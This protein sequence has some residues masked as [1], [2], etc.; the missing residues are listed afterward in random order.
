MSKLRKAAQGQ[1]CMVRLPDCDGGGDTTVL[2]HYRMAGYCGVGLKPDDE[3]AAW[4]C[5]PCHAAIDGRRKLDGWTREEIRLAHAEGVM[6]T[7]VERKRLEA[8]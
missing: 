4:A 7:A 1:P 8:A 2:A 6:R 5:D 3:M